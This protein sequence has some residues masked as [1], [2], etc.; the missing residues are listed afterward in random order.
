LH[1]LARTYM[2]CSDKCTQCP[3]WGHHTVFINNHVDYSR[4][5]NSSCTEFKCSNSTTMA[6][7]NIYH[8]FESLKKQLQ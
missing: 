3:T 7:Q 1:T 8:M 5:I 4:E 2:I 6:N